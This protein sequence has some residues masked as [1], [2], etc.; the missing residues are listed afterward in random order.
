MAARKIEGTCLCVSLDGIFMER[1]WAS[2]ARNVAISV[3]IGTIAKD[4][5][6]ILGITIEGSEGANPAWSGLLCLP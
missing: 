5:G 3:V 6:E 1:S 4:Y 2:A